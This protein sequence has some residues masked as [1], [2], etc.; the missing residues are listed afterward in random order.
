MNNLILKKIYPRPP[1][2]NYTNMAYD[3][4]GL[5]SIT[6]PIEAKLI[7]INI[8]KILNNI[9]NINNI[10]TPDKYSI[11]DMSAGCGGNIISFC[12]YFHTVTGIENNIER[13]QILKNNIAS[14]N[15]N[16]YNIIC[17]D[18]INFINSTLNIYDVYF[19]DPPWGGPTYKNNTNIELSMSG[20]TLVEIINMIPKNK[21]IVL[22]LP[23]NYNISTFNTFNLLFKMEIKNI[24]ILFLIKYII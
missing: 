5:Y 10:I 2:N 17:D 23:F 22:K 9:N 8:I 21:L 4:E 7:S 1:L 18:S 24:L 11:I 20:I 3:I 13:C 6:Y 15:Y 14:Y 16:N 19:I 12:E